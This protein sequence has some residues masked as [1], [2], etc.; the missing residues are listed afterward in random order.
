MKREKDIFDTSRG[1]GKKK[2]PKAPKAPIASG[3]IPTRRLIRHRDHAPTLVA[4]ACPCALDLQ[5]ADD[6]V[7]MARQPFAEP[8][9]VDRAAIARDGQK[10]FSKIG[11]DELRHR[12][13][14]G[15][16][17]GSGTPF[18]RPV[19][20]V[21]DRD[22]S[23][24]Y[25]CRPLDQNGAQRVQLRIHLPCG[26][27][28]LDGVFLA[29]PHQRAADPAFYKRLSEKL[30]KLIQDHQDN[31]EV[32]AEGYEGLRRE[33]QA[34]R[35]ETVEGLSREA[36]TFYDYVVQLAFDGGDVPEGSREALRK[37]MARIVEVLQ[38]TIDILDFWKK[39]IEVK[40]LRGNIDTEILL[41]GVPQLIEKHERIAVELVKL[42][43]RRHEDLTK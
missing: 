35:T 15:A 36:S 12:F 3:G 28:R 29:Q 6:T 41:S 42:A 23:F 11:G 22:T 18:R 34:G 38:D 2:A 40:R 24:T 43:E 39:P 31:W 26:L 20:D 30:E 4:R 10:C 32:L 14:Q 13:L 19:N 37:L 25:H 27:D 7:L 1:V 33:A 17:L 5:A 8:L 16:P 9:A 21:A